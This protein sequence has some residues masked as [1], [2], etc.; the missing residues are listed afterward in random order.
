[1]INIVILDT[2]IYRQLGLKF[3][4]HID[5]NGLEDYCYSSGA[6]ILVTNTVFQEYLDYY[7]KEIIDR[8][9]TDIERAYEKLKKLNGF[10]K[11][12]TPNL[13]KQRKEELLFIKNKLSKYKLKPRLDHFLN[14]QQLLEFLIEN[15]Q[16]NKK[17]NTRDYLI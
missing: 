15:K 2:N 11:I 17:D 8:N 10:T 9:I 5:Y 1:M 7:T 12:K 16:E 3:Y 6:E 14:E 13:T 4:D